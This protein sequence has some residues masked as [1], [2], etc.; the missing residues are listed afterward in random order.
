MSMRLPPW[1][2]WGM[3][4]LKSELEA[5]AARN[6]L[7]AG[8]PTQT[9]REQ[10][11]SEQEIIQERKS[12]FTANF[13]DAFSEFASEVRSLGGQ[14]NN[15]PMDYMGDSADSTMAFRMPNGAGS[16]SDGTFSV[17]LKPRSDQIT[18]VGDYYYRTTDE[19][20]TFSKRY[21]KNYSLNES[22]K[23]EVVEDLRLLLKSLIS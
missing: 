11:K 9:Q 10:G 17:K 4:D 3:S 23:E 20:T 12:A 6:R 2:R 21:E 13:V 15:R 22:R 5:I 7:A 16:N 14:A 19:G 8:G 1:I 18:I